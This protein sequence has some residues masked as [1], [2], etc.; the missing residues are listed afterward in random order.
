MNTTKNRTLWKWMLA[1][2]LAL[3]LLGGC[4]SGGGTS[5]SSSA[6]STGGGSAS[7]SSSTSTSSSS[8]STNGGSGDESSSG[9]TVTTLSADQELYV[10]IVAEV[11]AL[12]LKDKGNVLGRMRGSSVSYD[13]HDLPELNPQMGSGHYL[14]VVFPHSGWQKGENYAS[15]YHGLESVPQDEWDFVV[16]TD[17]TNASVVLRWEGTYLL[18]IKPDENNVARYVQTRDSTGEYIQAMY[19]VDVDNNTSVKA[20]KD[21]K[22]QYYAFSMDGSDERHFKWV[23]DF[24]GDYTPPPETTPA[25]TA[26]TPRNVQVRSVVQPRNGEIGPPPEP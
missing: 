11:P 24:N 15:D 20:V 6:T 17:V 22:L 1:I 26:Q 23:L 8:A 5:D 7:E 9:S 16:R 18:A 3:A 14:T 4:S 21:G 12:R 19:L 2:P 10:R 25:T 13:S